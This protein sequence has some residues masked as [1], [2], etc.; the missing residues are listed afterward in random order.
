MNRQLGPLVTFNLE[1]GP[2]GPDQTGCWRS[3][4]AADGRR[5]G[6]SWIERTAYG[7]WRGPCAARWRADA[8]AGCGTALHKRLRWEDSLDAVR[9]RS[10]RYSG[11]VSRHVG[12]MARG[13][14]H[15]DRH[16]STF[17]VVPVQ[18]CVGQC[19][20][21]D[22]RDRRSRAVLRP[23]AFLDIAD[24]LSPPPSAMRSLVLDLGILSPNLPAFPLN[25]SVV[26]PGSLY[27]L[28]S[29]GARGRLSA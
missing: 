7:G 3:P 22:A 12:L 18:H 20:N 4:I 6:S 26:V 14:R 27:D 1:A 17:G 5:D 2:L 16:W 8:G 15:A 21:V 23:R 9:R 28:K 19:I 10:A 24:S 13:D 25:T 11:V 29:L